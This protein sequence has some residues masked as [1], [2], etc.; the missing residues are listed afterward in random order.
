VVALELPALS[1]RA[2]LGDVPLIALTEF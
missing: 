2:R 1:G